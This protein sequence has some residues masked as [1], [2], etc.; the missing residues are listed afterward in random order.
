MAFFVKA[1]GTVIEVFDVE[2]NQ[3]IRKLHTTR[4]IHDIQLNDEN[5]FFISKHDLSFVFWDLTTARPLATYELTPIENLGSNKNFCHLT[6]SLDELNRPTIF[7]LQ[8]FFASPF[9]IK[10]SDNHG[11]KTSF[12]L[13]NG[14][15][16]WL[17][18]PFRLKLVKYIIY[19]KDKKIL[20]IFDTHSANTSRLDMTVFIITNLVGCVIRQIDG[21][22]IEKTL[23]LTE[24]YQ[25]SWAILKENIL[26][27]NVKSFIISYK[28][29]PDI[30]PD[31]TAINPS[32]TSAGQHD[33]RKTFSD[34]D[35]AGPA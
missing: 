15:H 22:E 9:H 13:F 17:D 35:G 1:L 30:T 16:R 3:V 19:P 18:S 11:R 7:F 10:I 2:K 4:P 8:L 12:E 21:F 25:F 27:I 26:M 33:K 29:S 5:T 14:P 23:N 6:L 31:A 32:P 28:F 34:G 24:Q 20:F